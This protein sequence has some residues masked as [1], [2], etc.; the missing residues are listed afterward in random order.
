MESAAVLDNVDKFDCIANFQPIQI[1]KFGDTSSFYELSSLDPRTGSYTPIYDLDYIPNDVN[2]AA[3]YTDGTTGEHTVIAAYYNSVTGEALLC[4]VG[5]TSGSCF[6]AS[7]PLFDGVAFLSPNVGACI[8][9]NY[10][11]G[12]GR[13]SHIV[14]NI[15]T[16]SPDATVPPTSDFPNAF[17]AQY[18]DVTELEETFFTNVDAI[19]DGVEAD[20]LLGLASTQDLIIHRLNADGDYDQVAVVPGIVI[21]WAGETPVEGTSHFGAAFSYYASGYPRVLF[22]ANDGWGIFELTL[23]I[24]IPNDCWHDSSGSTFLQCDMATATLTWR[25]G[26]EATSKNDGFNC[27]LGEIL[28]TNSPTLSGDPHLVGFQGQRFDVIG[29]PGAN[30]VLL[31][32]DRLQIVVKI[33][34]PSFEHS[35]AKQVRASGEHKGLYMDEVGVVFLDGG[36]DVQEVWVKSDYNSSVHGHE[37]HCGWRNVETTNCLRGMT[38]QVNGK[39]IISISTELNLGRDATFSVGNMDCPFADRT[40]ACEALHKN[41]GGYALATLKIPSITLEVG[42]Q[43]MNNH[44]MNARTLHHLDLDVSDYRPAGTPGGLLGQTVE[45]HYDEEGRPI[46]KGPGVIGGDEDVFMIDGMDAS[47]LVDTLYRPMSPLS[48]AVDG[49]SVV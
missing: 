30:Y 16:A 15:N 25:A 22:T 44:D 14:K 17:I 48:A 4:G 1:A 31:E 33:D 9:T 23:P 24:I 46:M 6:P 40:K 41:S 36:G 42:A 35:S 7:L 27:R 39:A 3:L 34:H 45:V 18:Y 13:A 2:G 37:R 5:A 19:E 29:K 28:A 12:K 10:Y 43:F 32:D 47:K 21:D 38:A 49:D 11:Y 26:S 8:G 20:Y